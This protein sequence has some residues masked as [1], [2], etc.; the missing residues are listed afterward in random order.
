[1]GTA[2]ISFGVGMAF[3]LSGFAAGKCA[4]LEAPRSSPPIV[5]APLYK[6][7][8]PGWLCRARPGRPKYYS[9]DYLGYPLYGAYG[10]YG[11]PLYWGQYTISGWGFRYR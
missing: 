8:A 3:L 5:V 10:P 2:V 11:G 7:C 1:M 4:E 9:N 6:G